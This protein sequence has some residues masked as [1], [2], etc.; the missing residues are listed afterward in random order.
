MYRIEKG[1]D[2]WRDREMDGWMKEA[3]VNKT[4]S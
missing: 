1:I 4:V 3:G 2:E